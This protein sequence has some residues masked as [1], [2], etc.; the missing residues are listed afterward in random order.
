MHLWRHE[1][2]DTSSI[3]FDPSGKMLVATIS[4]HL[5]TLYELSDPLP[6][7]TFSSPKPTPHEGYSNACT[8][9]ASLSPPRVVPFAHPSAERLFRRNSRQTLLRC[10]LGRFPH[11]RLVGPSSRPS[12]RPSALSPD[13]L[14]PRRL[15]HSLWLL[16]H[17]FVLPS[18]QT[19]LTLPTQRTNPLTTPRST[20]SSPTPSQPLPQPSPPTAQSSILPYSTP[21]SPSSSP[22]ES[23]R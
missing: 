5:P 19:L 1:T 13:P 3:V 10:R 2:P 12:P 4:K 20:P 17:R 9:K 11:L 15:V 8:I 7:A 22:P 16:R 6:L 18:S 23:R 14:A 21:P